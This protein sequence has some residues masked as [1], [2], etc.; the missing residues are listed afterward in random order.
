MVRFVILCL[1]ALFTFISLSLAYA[2]PMAGLFCGLQDSAEQVATAYNHG[3]YDEEDSVASALVSEGK[4]T[5]VDDPIDVSVVYRGKI[6]GKKIIVGVSRYRE[7]APELFG[8]ADYLAQD[9]GI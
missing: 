1:A 8:V 9:R 5:R 7:G 4:C 6:I 3:G 2:E